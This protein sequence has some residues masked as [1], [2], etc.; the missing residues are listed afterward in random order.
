[1]P[2]NK[3]KL[4]KP[5]DH[6]S[7]DM[8]NFEFSE[9]HLGLVSP[10]HFVYEFSRKM[11]LMLHFIY[12]WN[13]FVWLPLNLYILGNMCIIVV[14]EPVSDVT[15]FEINFMF[16]IKSFW[17]ITKMSRQKLKNHEDEKS[18]KGKINSIFHQ[19]YR[20]F[21]CQKL[22]Q[23]WQFAFKKLEQ[24]CCSSNLP[25]YHTWKNE[26]LEKQKT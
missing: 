3:N 21:S 7:K 20:T 11:F 9:L 15:K 24:T 12:W 2:H 18:F 22:S 1:M 19:F 8:I 6:W 4:Y 25:I 17:Y 23:I 16:L 13:L 5:L 26:T 14:G 10:P